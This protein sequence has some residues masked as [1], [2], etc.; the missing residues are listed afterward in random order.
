MIEQQNVSTYSTPKS[1]YIGISSR[2]LKLF[3]VTGLVPFLWCAIAFAGAIFHIPA[4]YVSNLET[5]VSFL[6]GT[7]IAAAIV[8]IGITLAQFVLFR[9]SPEKMGLIGARR[10]FFKGI[11]FGFLCILVWF[12]I[13]L[14]HGTLQVLGFAWNYRPIGELLWG[15]TVPLIQALSAAFLEEI[16]FRGYLLTVLKDNLGVGS[17]WSRVIVAVLISSTVFGYLHALSAIKEQNWALANAIFVLITSGGIVLAIS[18]LTRRN[19]WFAM[20]IHFAINFSTAL[21]APTGPKPDQ[22]FLFATE[23]RSPVDYY[24]MTIELMGVAAIG[25]LLIV[26]PTIQYTRRKPN[27]R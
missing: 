23:L 17:R 15:L 22:W 21:L 18:F 6:A 26:A 3:I 1:T 9:V 12:V 10:A 8:L 25:V 16:A 20:G 2:I 11:P 7:L 4:P 19:L 24:Q 27:G 5:L 13:E 14:Q